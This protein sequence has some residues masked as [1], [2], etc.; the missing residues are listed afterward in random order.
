MGLMASREGSCDGIGRQAEIGEPVRVHVEKAAQGL[1][2]GLPLPP[3]SEASTEG[4][5]EGVGRSI[6]ETWDSNGHL[7]I[8]SIGKASSFRI[9]DEG[10]REKSTGR[11]KKAG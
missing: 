7:S 5:A 11:D 6:V 1:M 8:S 3:G 9:H 2:P 10:G 4:A